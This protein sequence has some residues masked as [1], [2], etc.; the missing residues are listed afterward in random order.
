MSAVTIDPRLGGVV[1]E[2]PHPLLFATVSGAHLYGFPSPDSD[3]DLRGCHLLPL[4]QVVSLRGGEETIEISR[5]DDGFELDLVTHDAR[6]LFTMVLKRNGYVLEQIHSPLVVHAGPGFE[7]LRA[8]ARDCVT[9]H[10]AHH[11]FGFAATERKLLAKE[12]PPRIKPL[13]Y[14]YRVLLTGIQ[15]MR[16]GEIEANLP[17]LAEEYGLRFVPELVARKVEGKE[18]SLLAEGEL[19]EHERRFDELTARLEKEAAE[20]TLPEEPRGRAALD[21]LLVR[22]RLGRV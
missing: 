10:H 17:R 19:A 11:Y 2:Q 6:K 3:W 15:L 8:I 14:L 22:L 18:R 13:L 1:R 9:R 20:T 5:V 12:S 7:E 21:D 16:S 4:E